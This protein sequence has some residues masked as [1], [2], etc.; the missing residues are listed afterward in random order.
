M[1]DTEKK[2]KKTA[3]ETEQEQRKGERQRA[4]HSGDAE[5]RIAFKETKRQLERGLRTVRRKKGK[6]TEVHRGRGRER[7]F[8]ADTDEVIFINN[9]P[10]N[11]NRHRVCTDKDNFNGTICTCKHVCV[12]VFQDTL[13]LIYLSRADLSE[14]TA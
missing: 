1:D 12:P 10:T 5:R 2:K 6:A 9:T 7:K 8:S 4:R 11:T 13:P 14:N 3:E